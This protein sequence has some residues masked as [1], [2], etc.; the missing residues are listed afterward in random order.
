[1]AAEITN[2]EKIRL[3]PW[4]IAF[5][6]ANNVF[7]QLVYFGAP[8]VLFLSALSLSNTEIGFLLSLLPFFGILALAAAPHV[9]RLG[10]KR[11]YLITFNVRNVITAG[12]LFVPLVMAQS[13]AN[14]AVILVTVVMMGFAIFRALGDTALIPWI[15]EYIPNSIRGKHS[16]INDMVMRVSSIIA[17]AGAGYVLGLSSGLDRFMILIAVAIVFEVIAAYSVSHLPGGRP[18]AAG[19]TSYRNLL[20]AVRDKNFVLY[21]AGLGLVIVA[22]APLSFLPIFMKNQVGMSDSAIVWLQIGSVIGGFSA[23]YLLGWASDRYGSKP[24]ML[25]GLYVKA[26][27][28][29]G[30]LLMPR[31]SGL[32]LPIALAIWFIWGI[33][34]IAW[35]IGSG[36]LLYVKVVPTERKT[37]YMA[38]FYAAA[39]LIGGISQIS[40]GSV[41]DA[42][43]GISGRF[44]IFDLDP[45]TPLFVAAI[46]LNVCAVIFFS[47]VQADSSVSVGEFAGM[48]M[49]GNPV[50]ALQSLVRYYRSTDERA[51]VVT[52]ER[53]GQTKSL[54]TVDE[55]L[56][57]LKDPR[58]NV[59]FEAIISIARMGSEPRL[60]DALCAILD[61]TEI[62]LS[63]IAAWALGRM[64]S[65]R[66]LPT[67]RNGLYSGYRSLQAHCA[68]SL[69]TLRDKTVA[70][71]LLE[72]LQKEEDKGLR[73]AYSSA[74]GN[75]SM[76]EA[77]DTLL[78]VLESTDNEGARMELALAIARVVD[79][80]HQFI[81]LLRNVRHDP[82]TTASQALTAWKRKLDKS[83]APEL[84]TMIDDCA[85]QFAREHIDLG[86]S[87]LS[88]IIQALLLEPDSAVSTKVLKECARMLKQ[89]V[90]ARLEYLV[91][92]LC[93]LQ[94]RE[95]P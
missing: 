19:G 69:G 9:A 3:L 1:M 65:A 76:I 31:N 33:A 81:R 34:E 95:S 6:A 60:V 23:T 58:F 11:T 64:G 32:S 74:L 66:A 43:A 73:I 41:L 67:L 2:A 72:R 75:L 36:R 10:Y 83:N 24:V 4:N 39:G 29:L 7:V 53:M 61:G 82:G 55:M 37:E 86:A 28:P 48:F 56:E 92:A 52:T 13:G 44:L 47:R 5:N 8:F 46:V 45:F 87:L 70:P 49:H 59:R 78:Q 79:G 77:T 68:R 25:T 57:A 17:I 89:G 27:L 63:V 84:R 51:T 54:L 50:V 38:V 22:A 14:A 90:A 21:L 94:I 12:F 15:Q 93:L 40:S 16:A 42:F 35:A 18:V 62:S 88:D 71:L 26:L 20:L 85:N 80:E 30:W 91:L